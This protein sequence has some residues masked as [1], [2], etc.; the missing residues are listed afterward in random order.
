MKVICK[1]IIQLESEDIL[2]IGEEYLVLEL[3][4]IDGII[5]YRIKMNNNSTPLSFNANQFEISDHRI[6][7]TWAIDYTANNELW[8]SP[9]K[10]LDDS[11]WKYSFWE[12]YFSHTSPEAEKVFKEEVKKMIEESNNRDNV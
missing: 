10:W 2:I 5:N 8:I 1:K 7:S 11:L 12:D 3:L 9:A 4:V 6:P